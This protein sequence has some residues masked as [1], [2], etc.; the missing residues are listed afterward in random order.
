MKNLTLAEIKFACECVNYIVRLE[1]VGGLAAEPT[2]FPFL[3][4]AHVREC[5][6]KARDFGGLN[7]DGQTMA[8]EI[9]AD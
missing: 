8:D 7:L 2:T 4:E 1:D 6:Q 5:I 9:L 3:R